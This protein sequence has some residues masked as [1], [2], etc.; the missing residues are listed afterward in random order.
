MRDERGSWY[1]LTGF[2]LGAVLG[3][4]YAW[5]ISPVQYLETSPRTLNSEYKNSYRAMIA[6]AYLANADLPRAQARLNLLEDANIPAALAEQAQ[7]SLAGDGDPREAQALG[8]LA[9]AIRQAQNTDSP[10]PATTDASIPPPTASLPG[11]APE[12]PG[13]STDPQT[14]E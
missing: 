5:R 14:D 9:L 2:V 8:L 11:P 6:A 4:V 10:I 12:T 1:L 13:S 3:L 7:N